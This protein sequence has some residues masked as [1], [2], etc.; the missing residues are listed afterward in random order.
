MLKKVVSGLLSAFIML[1]MLSARVSSQNQPLN[2]DAMW[3]EPSVTR[4]SQDEP[5]HQ[6]GY[7]FNVTVC[8]RLDIECGAWQFRMLYDKVQLNA[9]RCGYTAGFKSQFFENISTVPVAPFFAP[10]NST[11]NRV[12]FAESWSGSGPFRSPGEGT[13]AW[14]EFEV[15]AEPHGEML[16]SWL[17]I[18]TFAKWPGPRTFV[19]VGPSRI[20]TVIPAYNG[21][22]QFLL[23]MTP[24]AIRVLSPQNLTYTVSSIPLA[25]TLNESAS[26]MGYSL[27]GQENVTIAGNTTLSGLAEG[28]HT[29]VLFANDTAG[30]MGFSENIS[31]S[32]DATPPTIVI[33][34]PE[35]LTYS[36]SSVPLN[37]TVSES[38]SW[39]GYSLDG[40]ASVTVTGNTTLT[41]LSD[42]SHS[43]VVYANDTIGNMGSSQVIFFSVEIHD[44][45]LTSIST[46]KNVVGEG[47]TINVSLTV[48]NQGKH[49]EVFNMTIYANDTVIGTLESISLEG[50]G[51]VTLEL[52]WDTSGFAKGNYTMSAY[53]TILPEEANT[54][55]NSCTDGTVHVGIPGEVTGDHYVGIDDIFE[56][57][58]HFGEDP[59]SPGWDGKYD[60]TNDEYVGVDDIFI[61]AS[62]FGQEE[63]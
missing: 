35:N 38:A 41:G 7:R 25:F 4:L 55:N 49:F 62:N 9:T 43:I 14:L 13:L 57:A 32:V 39:M 3:I 58:S 19:I 29:I 50:N 36:N 8:I 31:F 12:D 10:Q 6:I 34:Q 11:H 59:G 26:W 15:L 16:E 61:A 5:E 52:R 63:S 42:G 44:I 46:T 53:A 51:S 54:T 33:L 22:Y 17:D 1:G 21:L 45:A 40:Q 47:Y 20:K 56:I 27:D 30:N 24:P 60:I 23:D 48:T 2:G 28:L 18:S 37:F